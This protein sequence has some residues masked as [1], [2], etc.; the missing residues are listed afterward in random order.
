MPQTS[1]LLRDADM[2]L[3]QVYAIVFIVFAISNRTVIVSATI[4]ASG[5][6][7][8]I[9]SFEYSVQIKNGADNTIKKKYNE[10][11]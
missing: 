8:V 1:G 7:F 11:L 4:F 9:V 2:P 3:F 6:W 10:L 5:L